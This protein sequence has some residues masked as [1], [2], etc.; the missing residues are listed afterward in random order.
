MSTPEDRPVWENHPLWSD[1]ARLERIR[2]QMW[3]EIQKV[4]FPGRPRRGLAHRERIELTVV[5]GTSAEDVFSE[6]VT[7]LL[8][9]VPEGDVNWEATGNTIA[10]R[11]AVAAVRK[12]RKHRRLPDGSEV[13]ITSLEQSDQEGDPRYDRLAVSDD[14]PDEEAT[15]R[16]LRADRLLAFRAVADEILP[17]RD[18]DIVFRAARGETYVSISS[19]VNLSQ[20][21]VGQ[22]DRESLRKIN[23]RLRADPQ[24]RRLYEPEGGT[25]ND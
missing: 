5:G 21:R 7:A 13:D 12:A 8:R 25:P 24:Y 6:A 2:Q 1:R 20:Q 10:Q 16:A 17:Q 14:A 18:R 15:D 19:A 22:I 23:A 11:R 3:I 4:M 9:Y